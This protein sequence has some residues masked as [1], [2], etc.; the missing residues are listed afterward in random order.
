MEHSR[1][2]DFIIFA[3]NSI[4]SP[5][6]KNEES[7][8]ILNDV[9]KTTSVTNEKNAKNDKNKNDSN[10]KNNSNKNDNNKNDNNKNKNNVSNKKNKNNIVV[11][12][13]MAGVG[14]FA[15]P[16]AMNNI[17]VHANDLNPES[18]KYLNKNMKMNHCEKFLKTENKC[19]R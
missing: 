4:S 3:A 6:T 12:D 13:M 2:V 9:D 17:T 19:G 10:K 7:S 8:T 15:V 18:F 16:L 11:A 1:L 14:P 5:N